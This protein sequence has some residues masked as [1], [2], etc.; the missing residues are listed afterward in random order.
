MAS[1]TFTSASGSSSM[2]RL[3]P[4]RSPGCSAKVRSSDVSA[5]TISASPRSITRFAMSLRSILP[6][7][8]MPVTRTPDRWKSAILPRAVPMCG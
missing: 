6:P 7:R 8:R 2:E 4:T 5:T 1:T 3:R